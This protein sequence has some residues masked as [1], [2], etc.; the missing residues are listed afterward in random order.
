M[1]FDELK[2][3]LIRKGWKVHK[4]DP[5]YDETNLIRWNATKSV[6]YNA[7]IAAT[8]F[9]R[10]HK[11][12]GIVQ[13]EVAFGVSVVADNVTDLRSRGATF[14]ASVERVPITAIQPATLSRVEDLLTTVAAAVT[15]A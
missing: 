14:F 13:T 1:D 12:T 8:P 2:A 3:E 15:R 9:D 6:G 7:V 10:K 4:T 5:E 11:S